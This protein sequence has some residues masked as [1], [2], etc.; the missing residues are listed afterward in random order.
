MHK[1]SI[2]YDIGKNHEDKE[3]FM[4]EAAFPELRGKKKTDK[5]AR[6]AP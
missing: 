1:N 3:I 4:K 5:G 2:T 6:G